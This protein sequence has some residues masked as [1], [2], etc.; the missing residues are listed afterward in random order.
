[1][2]LQA[3]VTALSNK[4]RINPAAVTTQPLNLPTRVDPSKVTQGEQAV[5]ASGSA[6]ASTPVP[7]TPVQAIPASP[8]PVTAVPVDAS[9]TSVTAVQPLN[10]QA[11][12]AQPTPVQ[13][14]Q[15]LEVRGLDPAA[16][17]STL[18]PAAGQAGPVG[19]TTGSATVGDG[20]TT[21]RPVEPNPI[22]RHFQ[23]VGAL[24]TNP[25]QRAQIGATAMYVLSK[26]P[27]AGLQGSVAP[28]SLGAVI[29]LATSN[30]IGP[31]KPFKQTPNT[32]FRA[33]GYAVC[34]G[35]STCKTNVDTV[36][37][38]IASIGNNGQQKTVY[39]LYTL[40]LTISGGLEKQDIAGL[41]DK[42][43]ETNKIYSNDARRTVGFIHALQQVE[44]K[45]DQVNSSPSHIYGPAVADSAIELSGAK[46]F[47]GAFTGKDADTGATLTSRQ[48]WTSVGMSGVAVVGAVF[49]GVGGEEAAMAVRA[50]VKATTKIGDVVITD[51][52][53]TARAARFADAS[54]QTLISDQIAAK[55]AKTGD[56]I[57]NGN[58]A[59]A[60][61]EIGVIQQAFD[62]G[63]TKGLD[64]EMTVVGSS[65]CSYCLSALPKM[66]KA[67]GLKSL[68]V[69]EKE[70]GKTLQIYP[71]VKRNGP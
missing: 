56:I 12:T 18:T 27:D 55:S 39:T 67:A 71:R 52:N 65:V 42:N 26:D 19:S 64:M 51:V 37:K 23:E 16:V 59:T 49:S 13:S 36:D 70:T 57:P 47:Y 1:V 33:A 7:S 69:L 50:S 35:D 6:G 44:A 3:P 8:A 11:M 32:V 68:V 31:V 46:D 10:T 15:S 48:R 58:M 22:K 14:V 9:S 20:T 61:A 24:A 21:A 17:T 40:G 2:T 43:S 45:R 29:A 30:M 28:Q 38:R 41:A 60:H 54:K 34:K 62:L 63:L 66:A 4:L 25:E 53:Q 5:P